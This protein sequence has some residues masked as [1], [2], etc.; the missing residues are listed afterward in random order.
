[1][2]K[3]NKHIIG[4]RA[5]IEAISSGMEIE[6]ILFRNGIKS[7]LFQE[8]FKIVKQRQI[9]FQYVPSEKLNRTNSGNHQGVIGFVS[10]IVY[11]NIEL[12]IPMLFEQGK[13]PFI[14]VLDRVT[15]VRNFGAIARTAEC[16]G[17]NAILIPNKGSAQIGSDAMKT[18]AGALNHIMV[19]RADKLDKSLILLKNSGLK[20][21]SATEKANKNYTEINYRYPMAIVIGSEENG[22]SEEILKMSDE[23]VK[24]PIL[25]NIESLNVSVA[26]GIILYEA[27][28]QRTLN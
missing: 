9:P 4:V 8:L 22:V 11:Q 15:D 23:K 17:V 2:K 21:I 28:K 3:K 14:L 24:I 16:A 25:G 12:I 26:C 6:K 10:P 20:I 5:N 19:C 7:D 1:M 18:S 27:V 13:V